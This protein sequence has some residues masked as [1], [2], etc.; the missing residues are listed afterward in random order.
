MSINS[1]VIPYEITFA[2]VIALVALLPGPALARVSRILIV[3]YVPFALALS[4]YYL[5][6]KDT[7]HESHEDEGVPDTTRYLRAMR[8]SS[9]VYAVLNIVLLVGA[10][11]LGVPYSSVAYNY[12]SLFVTSMIVYI[13]DRCVSTDDGLGHL[14]HDPAMT[15]LDSYLSFCSPSFMRYL[16]VLAAEI[17]LMIIIA[18]YIGALIPSHCWVASTLFRKSIVPVVVFAI[19]GGPLRF[20]W[21]YPTVSEAGRIPYL[22]AYAIA[23]VILAMVTYASGSIRPSAAAG[24]LILMAVIAVILQLGGFSNAPH[25]PDVYND[26]NVMPRWAMAFLATLILISTLMIG[27]RI[28]VNYLKPFV[29]STPER[30]SGSP[31]RKV[32]VH[33][34]QNHKSKSSL[35]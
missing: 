16:I 13:Y 8:R 2:V 9:A 25:I 27:Y 32:K 24:V 21:A 20:A 11:M 4:I 35:R 33:K 19:V 15:I 12:V 26:A 29:L 34:I 3:L 7:W 6:Q 23:F 30:E 28:F 1:S 22:L 14:K 10:K 5:S 18:Y 17:S 31:R